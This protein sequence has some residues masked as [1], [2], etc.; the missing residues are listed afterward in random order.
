MNSNNTN[1]NINNAKKTFDLI[2]KKYD[3]SLGYL[4]SIAMLQV[5]LVHILYQIDM[6]N[7]DIFPGIAKSI[8]LFEM[9]LLFFLTGANNYSNYKG[10]YWK[11][12]LCRMI[13]IYI[14]YLLFASINIIVLCANQGFQPI[15]LVWL[16]PINF[17]FAPIAPGIELCRGVIWWF[18]PYIC[19]L[20]VI[21]FLKK[22]YDRFSNIGVKIIPLCVIFIIVIILTWYYNFNNCQQTSFIFW[23]FLF[24]GFLFFTYLGFFYQRYF[25]EL[26]LQKILILS[27]VGF[28]SLF[29]L[30]M[31]IINSNSFTYDMMFNKFPP[32]FIYILF[33]NVWLWF[34]IIFL[35]WITKAFDTLCKIKLFR[36]FI[37]GYD[38]KSYL[39][40]LSHTFV[41]ELFWF[42]LLD[43]ANAFNFFNTYRVFYFLINIILLYPLS[44]PSA[45]AFYPLDLIAKK[46]NKKILNLKLKQILIN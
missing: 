39:I 15:N 37:H 25:K 36:F 6:G 14:P 16:C 5:L 2:D 43:K 46:L 3:R 28:I 11:Y 32:N 20:F 45:Y 17:K 31:T 23:F 9:P 4:R 13:R 18:N 24:I 12:I 19:I 42:V 38:S 44:L 22:F 29:I 10:G 40:F 33:G 27:L 8:I 30:I 35:K 34:F 41:F 21:P 1:M 26:D 7:I